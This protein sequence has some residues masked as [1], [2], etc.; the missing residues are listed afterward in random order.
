[1]CRSRWSRSRWC[2]GVSRRD[3]AGLILGAA[4]ACGLGWGL[5]RGNSAGWTSTGVLTTLVAGALL[6]VAFVLREAQTNE[7][8]LHMRLFRSAAFSAGNAVIF[9]LNAS[10]TGAVFFMA[11]FQQVTLGRGPLDA[12]L[13]LL[14]WGVVPVLIAPRAG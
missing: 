13:R 8:M 10:L 11:Q 2:S 5:V 6:G 4:A 9:L 12:G 3:V 7:A 1:M 14:P